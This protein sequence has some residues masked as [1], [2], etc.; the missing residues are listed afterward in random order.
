MTLQVGLAQRLSLRQLP[1]EEGEMGERYDDRPMDVK[2][3]EAREMLREK[4]GVD[5]RT[6]PRDLANKHDRKTNA[7]ADH[8]ERSLQEKRR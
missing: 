5:R 6:G 7:L 3:Q 1:L 4:D 2:R 8:L